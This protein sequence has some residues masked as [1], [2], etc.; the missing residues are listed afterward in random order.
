MSLD[1]LERAMGLRAPEPS[2]GVPPRAKS[3]KARGGRPS[4]VRRRIL[5]AL[6]GGKMLQNDL[7]DKL[8]LKR[9]GYLSHLLKEMELDG[10][11]VRRSVVGPNRAPAKEVEL[12]CPQT[13]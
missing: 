3:L 6:A 2:G 1:A 10:L 8:G 9:N 11:L 7:D 5:D 4:D 13:T 12:R